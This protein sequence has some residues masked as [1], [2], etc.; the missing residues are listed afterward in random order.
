MIQLKISG[1]DEKKVAQTVEQVAD[2]L[3]QLLS[4][5]PEIGETI[6][7]LG[8]IEAAIHRI[9]SRFRWQ[10]LI[11]G[12]SS[13]NLSRLVKSM[14]AILKVKAMKQVAITIDVDPYSLM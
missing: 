12:P 5:T 10:I 13:T 8:P 6:Q 3:N 7:I 1:R 9:S 11:K 2:V 4:A 14:K